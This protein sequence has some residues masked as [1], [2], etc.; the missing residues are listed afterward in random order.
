LHSRVSLFAIALFAVLCC[1]LACSGSRPSASR[2]LVLIVI[3]TLRY[4]RL[5]CTG[6]ARARTPQLDALAARG[7]L[8]REAMTPVPVTLP[9]VT[10]LLTG[11]APQHHG[12]R[13]NDRFTLAAAE[14]T[15]AERF[16]AA[17]WRTAAVLGSSVLSADRGLDQGF[18]EYNDRFGGT[19]PVYDPNFQVSDRGFGTSRRRADV[20]TDAAL[21]NLGRF[22]DDPFFLFVHYFDVHTNYDPPPRFRTL[23]PGRAY[24]GEVS[25]VDAEIGRLLDRIRETRTDATVI[26]VSDHG[27]GLGDHGET[28]HGFLLY[29]STLAVPI[30]AAGPGI[31]EGAV[32][33]D[34]VSL[35]DLEPTLTSWFSLGNP[36][37]RDGAV[38]AWDTPQA[39][40]RPLYAETMRTLLTYGWSE[41]R[42]VRRGSWKLIAGPDREVYDLSADPGE[43][44]PLD[45]APPGSGLEDALGDLVGGETRAGVLASVRPDVDPGREE[46]LESLGYVGGAG[47]G[48]TAATLPHPRDAL[49]R[50]TD[51]QRAKELVRLGVNHIVGGRF[52]EAIAL[53]DSALVLDPAGANALYSRGRARI[54]LGDEAGVADIERALEVEPDNVPALSF[55]AMRSEEKGEAE[56]AIAMWRRVLAVDL[57]S[58][59]SPLTVLGQPSPNQILLRGVPGEFAGR[60]ER[61]PRDP[62]AFLDLGIVLMRADRDVEAADAF[63]TF[64]E[65]SRGR[66]EFAEFRRRLVA[67][68]P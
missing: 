13:D 49:P 30:I 1:G 48:E 19:Y 39:E 9:A 57:P 50:W 17:G 58:G 15:L 16:R 61:N 4:D 56:D 7:V 52:A 38:L 59:L 64:V 66:P 23:H 41:L 14:T 8:F 25:F 47:P 10:S 60:A 24:D 34:P 27:E 53:L 45:D 21:W 37:G 63:R 55:L 22:G 26:V 31:P 5:G 36:S 46:L 68:L 29:Q 44:R 43:T 12:V 51:A 6:Y 33:D 54:G 11:R 65:L 35:V 2:A 32:R 28:L 20:V 40:A 18:E 67:A 3:D 42:A 62:E